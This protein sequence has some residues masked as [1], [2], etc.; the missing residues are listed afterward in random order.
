MAT[1]VEEDGI[2]EVGT[3]EGEP[4]SDS[5]LGS[6]CLVEL[7][8]LLPTMQHPITQDPATATPLLQSRPPLGTGAIRISN[9]TRMWPVAQRH[10]DR[11]SSKTKVGLARLHFRS[12][13]SRPVISTLPLSV[14]CL[15]RTFRSAM[16]S[17]QG[18]WKRRTR[19]SFRASYAGPLQ[20]VASVRHR[21]PDTLH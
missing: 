9:I 14:N 7:W 5:A 2:V 8:L 16:S 10:G 19:M 11:W 21:G 4:L 13:T 12:R 3:V 15:R 1:A 18:S 20:P 17:S 6:G